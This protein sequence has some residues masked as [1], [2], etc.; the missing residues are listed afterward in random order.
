MTTPA[1][2]PPPPAPHANETKGVFAARELLRQRMGTG[3]ASFFLGLAFFAAVFVFLLFQVLPRLTGSVPAAGLAGFAIGLIYLIL[4]TVWAV[5]WALVVQLNLLIDDVAGWV[6]SILAQ[7]IVILRKQF[8]GGVIIDLEV[9]QTQV[10][11]LIAV[12][13]SK[14]FPQDSPLLPLVNEWAPIATREGLRYT[15]MRVAGTLWSGHQLTIET[16]EREAARLSIDEMAAR[17]RP[18]LRIAMGLVVALGLVL[19]ALPLGIVYGL[20]LLF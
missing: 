15:V 20:A 16:L 10:Q 14:L 2:I 11:A 7:V 4:G 6:Q 12:Q 18:W 1:V 8:A 19:A 17:I 5:L 13:T 9:V 3:K